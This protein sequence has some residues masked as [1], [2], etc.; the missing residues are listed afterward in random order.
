MR[1]EKE[2]DLIDRREAIAM[3]LTLGGFLFA[4]TG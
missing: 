1:L 4:L 3:M 2:N